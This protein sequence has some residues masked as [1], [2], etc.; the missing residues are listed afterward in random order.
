[1]ELYLPQFHPCNIWTR[2]EGMHGT[3]LSIAGCTNFKSP[4]MS[5]WAISAR[6]LDILSYKVSVFRIMANL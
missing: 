5:S 3:T 4:S 6:N 2:E 1:L